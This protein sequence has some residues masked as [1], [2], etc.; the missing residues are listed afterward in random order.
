MLDIF[1]DPAFPNLPRLRRGWDSAREKIWTELKLPILQN[2]NISRAVD[3]ETL[4]DAEGTF[5]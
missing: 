1:E 5:S 3:N 2:N 4:Y